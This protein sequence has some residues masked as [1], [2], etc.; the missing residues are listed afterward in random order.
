MNLLASFC[1]VY[2]L[3]LECSSHDKLSVITKVF[4]SKALSSLMSLR[5]RLYII[6]HCLL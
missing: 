3:Y 2:P 5:T 1:I 4:A 6:T